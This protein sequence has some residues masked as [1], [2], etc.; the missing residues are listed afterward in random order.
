MVAAFAAPG[1][2]RAALR[3]IRAINPTDRKTFALA[4]DSTRSV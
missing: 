1:F 2:E 3:S 4:S